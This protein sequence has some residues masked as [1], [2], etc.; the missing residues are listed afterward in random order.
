VPMVEVR[1]DLV[2]GSVDDRHREA[3]VVDR[4]VAVV[5]EPVTGRLVG[6]A[7]LAD[8]VARSVDPGVARRP[9]ARATAG[10]GGPGAPAEGAR[11]RRRLERIVRRAVAVV[12]EAVAELGRRLHAARARAPLARDAGLGAALAHAGALAARLRGAVHAG[13][14]LVGRP[15]AVVV[16]AVAAA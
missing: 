9:T 7:V 3:A 8:E 14:A 16:E 15:V 2:G 5:V 10:P 6:R 1:I 12:V 4:P 11:A 13:A